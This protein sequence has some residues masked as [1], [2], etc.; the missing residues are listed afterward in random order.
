MA[1][2]RFG[3]G[4]EDGRRDITRAG[5]HEQPRWRLE[6]SERLH[7]RRLKRRLDAGN[8]FESPLS[9]KRYGVFSKSS[10]R[11]ERGSAALS[12]RS[13]LFSERESVTRS[14]FA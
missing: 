10:F 12:T 4:F 9:L 11:L 6:S 14:S 1:D 8:E 7:G 13:G 3:H 5:S 2:E